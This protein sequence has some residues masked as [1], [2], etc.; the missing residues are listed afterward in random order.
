M[1]WRRREAEP[2]PRMRNVTVL[3]LAEVLG[4]TET[5]T[6]VIIDKH[7]HMHFFTYNNVLV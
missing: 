2:E 5:S 7:Q 6:N 4:P 3:K 1:P